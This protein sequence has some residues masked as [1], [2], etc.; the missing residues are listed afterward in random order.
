MTPVYDPYA[1]AQRCARIAADPLTLQSTRAAA[2]MTGRRAFAA[3]A[4][5]LSERARVSRNHAHAAVLVAAQHSAAGRMGH[6]HGLR[7]MAGDSL[8]DLTR[9]RGGPL[10]WS[11]EASAR[12]LARRT[13]AKGV[14]A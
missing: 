9:E 13:A 2:V 5:R 3:T 8:A 14:G 10:P 1:L 12:L 6:A 11:H 7:L 4:P